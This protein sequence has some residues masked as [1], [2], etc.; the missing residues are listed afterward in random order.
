MANNE[1]T[2][3][4]LQKLIE[5]CRDGQNGYREAAENVDDHQ[6]RQFFNEQSLERA[7]FAGELENHVQ[8]LG[9]HDPNRSGSMRGTLHRKWF[10]LKQALG[11]GIASVLSSV[12]QGEDRAKEQY[13]EALRDESLP[14]DIRAVVRQQADRVISA[15]DRVRDLR[16]RYKKAA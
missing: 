5:T 3:N 10:D 7:Q 14:S 2:I 12:E 1:S 11:G 8:R 13:D 9:E 15:H 6:L 4:V 16:D